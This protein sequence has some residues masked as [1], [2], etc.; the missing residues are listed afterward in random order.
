MYA[1]YPEPND[2][3]LKKV[4]FG[5]SLLYANAALFKRKLY[6]NKTYSTKKLPVPVISVGN[7]AVGGTGKTPMTIYLAKL[8]RRQNYSP[9]ILSRGYGGDFEKKGGIVSDGNS[10]LADS[11]LAGDEPLMMA[12]ALSGIPVLVG[13][14]RYQSGLWAVKEFGC[15]IVLLDD[16]FQHLR[17]YRDLNIVLLDA[18][19]PI[20]NGHVLPRGILREPYCALS[21]AHTVV[22]T[23]TPLKRPSI[24]CKVAKYIKP[25]LRFWAGQKNY[26]Y[27]YFDGVKTG[28]LVN[29][30]HLRGK[31]V[32]L[33]SGIARNDDF[34]HTLKMMGAKIMGH[35]RF[36]DHHRFSKQEI[37]DVM[38]RANKTTSE[39]IVTTEKDFT[40][41]AVPIQWTLPFLAIGVKMT[42]SNHTFDRFVMRSIGITG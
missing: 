6:Q 20:G 13:R 19:R 28:N 18:K 10:I 39:L 32:Y 29:L 42:F 33:F 22:F 38:E 14:N 27:Y 5:T 9:A 2:T 24:P 34:L 36:G 40:R 41:I 17:L 7:L 37:R 30:S 31:K 1:P 21:S 12:K 8:L 23:R 11:I 4:L 35:I 16:G 26:P 3:G 15:N 25:H